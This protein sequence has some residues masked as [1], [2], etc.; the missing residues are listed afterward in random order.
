MHSTAPKIYAELLLPKGHG[1]PM[2]CPAPNEVLPQHYQNNG[3]D[4][5]DVGLI[6]EEGA[7]D[8]LFNVFLPPDHIIN[9]A[10]G[11]PEDFQPLEKQPNQLHVDSRYHSARSPISSKGTKSYVLDLEGSMPIPGPPGVT[12]GGGIELKFSRSSG[13]VL[14][15]SK[16]AGRT[17]YMDRRTLAEYAVN[18][19]E[20]WYQYV[21]GPLGRQA[22]SGD[23]YLV[24]GVDKASD[25]EVA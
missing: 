20:S 22:C 23:L 1:Y 18:N 6:T 19:A 17:N 9:Q 14:M 16:G 2:W 10:R 7:F 3:V 24:T 13:A 25:W 15:L 12:V 11:V 21:N 5:G 4:V 8:F